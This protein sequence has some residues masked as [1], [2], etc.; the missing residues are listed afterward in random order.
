MKRWVLRCFSE[1]CNRGTVSYLEGERVP[2]K[3][4]IVTE[5][6]REV[7]NLFMNST[8]KSGCM[9]ELEFMG[10]TPSISGRSVGVN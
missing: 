8:V 10:T 6:I 7:F 2:K 1:R 3:W 4:G 5:R 9:K